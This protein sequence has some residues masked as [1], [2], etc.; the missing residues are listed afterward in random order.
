LRYF[1]D[2]ER[3]T[4]A[5]AY[6]IDPEVCR[7]KISFSEADNYRSW[8]K[9]LTRQAAFNAHG[10]RRARLPFVRQTIKDALK[11][12]GETPFRTSA[13]KA[14]ITENRAQERA[15]ERSAGFNGA[16]PHPSAPTSMPSIVNASDNSAKPGKAK[17]LQ[18]LWSKIDAVSKT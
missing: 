13:A 15:N 6:N 4:W 8:Q 14:S 11:E 5:P 17:K 16:L 7:L 1:Y 9:T 2:R 18:Q 10:M 3:N 12:K